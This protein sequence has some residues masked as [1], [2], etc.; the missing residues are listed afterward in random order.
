MGK[1]I[2]KCNCGREHDIGELMTAIITRLIASS[3]TTAEVKAKT[4]IETKSKGGKK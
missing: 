1:H 4:E 3:G 2:L